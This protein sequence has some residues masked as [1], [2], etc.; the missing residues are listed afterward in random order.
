MLSIAGRIIGALFFKD[1]RRVQLETDLIVRM[2]GCRVS[3]PFFFEPNWDAIVRPLPAALRI[4]D[5][6][7]T[8]SSGEASLDVDGV[9]IKKPRKG[10]VYQE[11]KYGDFLLK[12][13]TNNFAGGG[14]YA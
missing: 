14:K 4:L 12:K 1:C 13:V 2:W 3:I 8:S 6:A 10:K 5:A 9:P 7:Q 11:V